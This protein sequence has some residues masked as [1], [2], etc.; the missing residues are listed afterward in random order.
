LS[1]K[2]RHYFLL[3]TEETN[4]ANAPWL[5]SAEIRQKRALGTVR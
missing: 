4:T 3:C 1:V 2:D 5:I